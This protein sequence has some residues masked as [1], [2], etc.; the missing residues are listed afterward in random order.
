MRKLEKENQQNSQIQ[1]VLQRIENQINDNKTKI[2]E[3]KNFISS[4]FK[5]LKTNHQDEMNRIE[6]LQYQIDYLKNQ[7][8]DIPKNSEFENTSKLLFESTNFIKRNL[9]DSIRHSNEL[10]SR[11]MSKINSNVITKI[12]NLKSE[13][14]N[15]HRSN[16]TQFNN[17]QKEIQNINKEN[18]TNINQFRN[19]IMATLTQNQTNLFNY[20]DD[21][22]G[23]VIFAHKDNQLDGIFNY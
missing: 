18:Q 13:I 17:I 8:L 21:A 23:I 14:E 16:Q 19:S 22:N 3:I 20:I 1:S 11:L 5:T 2:D 4:E 6:L 15:S 9:D 12:T 7:I 10:H